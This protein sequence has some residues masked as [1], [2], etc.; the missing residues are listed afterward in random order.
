MQ[1]LQ[2]SSAVRF[3][4]QVSSLAEP[5]HQPQQIVLSVPAG[6]GA[7]AGAGRK[8]ASIS[9]KTESQDVVNRWSLSPTTPTSKQTFKGDILKKTKSTMKAKCGWSGPTLSDAKVT[10][11]SV[12]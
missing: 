1:F 10:P 5:S 12:Y 11:A 9:P 4:R 3:T 7:G 6:A 2:R 8:R